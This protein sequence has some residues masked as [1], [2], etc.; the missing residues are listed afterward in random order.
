MYSADML[1]P[2]RDPSNLK[3]WRDILCQRA[4]AQPNDT[5]KSTKLESSWST[6]GRTDESH[7]AGI[8]FQHVTTRA[9]RA[10][11]GEIAGRGGRVPGPRSL[12]STII[13]GIPSS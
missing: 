4:H 1:V 13:F 5:A 8:D 6:D 2:K 12:T 3:R 11:G 10:R 9:E 7:P